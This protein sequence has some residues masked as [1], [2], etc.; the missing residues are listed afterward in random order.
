MTFGIFLVFFS[1]LDGA[2][3][4]RLLGDEMLDIG[5]VGGLLLL[6]RLGVSVV[7]CEMFVG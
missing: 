2:R 1:W 6:W 3:E 4:E 7:G 5:L